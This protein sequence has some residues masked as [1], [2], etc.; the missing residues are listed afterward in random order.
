MTTFIIATR[1]RHKVQ[2][3]RTI[4]GDTFRYLSLE[5][6]PGAPAIRE[7]AP[8]FMGNAALKADGLAKWLAETPA[9]AAAAKLADRGDVLVLAD[10]SGLE[11]DA[12]AGAPGVHSARFAALDAGTEGNS[13]DAANSAKLLRLLAQV[14]AAKRTAR[15]QC[16]IAVAP[17]PWSGEVS[18]FG[19]ACEGRI[20]TEPSGTG[21]FGY[22]PLFIPNGFTQS[23]AELGEE[24]KNRLSH[25]AAALIRMRRELLLE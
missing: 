14:P 9:A 15:F 24:T 23:F 4:L 7:D 8:T 3:I 20:A 1:N 22:D 25:R 5:D 17:V 19:G 16:M 11:V 12:L 18:F 13:P 2:E 6:F 10:D 21:G